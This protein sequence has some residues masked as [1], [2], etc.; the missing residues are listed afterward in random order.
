MQICLQETDLISGNLT[1]PAGSILESRNKKPEEMTRKRKSEDISAVDSD[2][3]SLNKSH[4]T[5]DQIKAIIKSGDC[6]QLDDVIKAGQIVDINMTNKSNSSNL[7]IEACKKGSVECV[8]ILLENEA[9]INS[10]F[11]VQVLI[12]ASRSGNSVL[13]EYLIE[14]GIIFSDELL[15]LVISSARDILIDTAISTILIERFKDI[16]YSGCD[17]LYFVSEAGNVD[18]VR[19]ALVRGASQVGE[20]LLAAVCK[21]HTEVVKLLLNWSP[22]GER[23]PMEMLKQALKSAVY[24]RYIDIVRVLVEYGVDANIL[25]DAF[26]QSVASNKIEFAE[27]LLDNGADI[28]VAVAYDYRI[29]FR[30]TGKQ[31]STALL[32]F[33]LARGADLSERGEIPLRDALLCPDVIQLL[34][35]A[36]A[37]PNQHFADGGTALLDVAISTGDTA[38]SVLSILL[39][40][41]ADPNLSRTDT[42]ETPLMAAASAERTDRVKLLLEYGADVTQLNRAGQGVLDILGNTWQY[43][44]V[45]K[46]CKQYNDSNLPGAKPVLK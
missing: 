46:L 2:P 19:M 32:R 31:D 40:Q 15:L 29:L 5:Y 26:R 17:V 28:N 25:N 27:Y 30:I 1:I 37:N 14:K 44:K 6:D 8:K 20:A 18:I 12:C 34:L 7:L 22:R 23:I 16:D 43:R 10:S 35:Q 41:D 42:G 24:H 45:V 13:L 39:Q 9:N 4:L 11:N 38:F 36:G 3:N 33:L 21:D